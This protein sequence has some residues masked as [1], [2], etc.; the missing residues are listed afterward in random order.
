LSSEA[1]PPLRPP[2]ALLLVFC[3]FAGSIAVALLGSAFEARSDYAAVHFLVAARVIAPLGALAFGLWRWA[4]DEPLGRA[5]GLGMPQGREWLL[6]ALGAIA[7]VAIIPAGR[8]LFDWGNEVV[9]AVELPAEM[10][11]ADQLVRDNRSVQLYFLIGSVLAVIPFELLFRGFVQPRLARTAGRWSAAIMTVLLI[12]LVQLN[13]RIAPMMLLMAGVIGIV[14]AVSTGVWPA[15]VTAVVMI[16]V[17][18]GLRMAG[19]DPLVTPTTVAVGAGVAA[20]ALALAVA[21]ALRPGRS[22]VR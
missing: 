3:Y 10:L 13:A 2:G 15:L 19:Y 8:A 22:A 21:L 18:A 12:L 1:P 6:V 16:G 11:A 20:L 17:Q 9:A 14:R 7:A 4:P 5:L